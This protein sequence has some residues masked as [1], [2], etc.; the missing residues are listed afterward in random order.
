MKNCKELLLVFTVVVVLTLV[1]FLALAQCV[2]QEEHAKRL[3]YGHTATAMN[4]EAKYRAG[5]WLRGGCDNER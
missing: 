1:A 4:V 5:V 3:N 2:L